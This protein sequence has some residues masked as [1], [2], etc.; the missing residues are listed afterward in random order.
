[1]FFLCK[2]KFLGHIISEFT[3]VISRIEDIKGLKTPESTF[4]VL[5]VIGAQIVRSSRK[6]GKIKRKIKIKGR[7]ED[8]L[9]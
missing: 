3:P 9:Y 1:M 6:D 8:L 4:D 5:S 2:V 7:W